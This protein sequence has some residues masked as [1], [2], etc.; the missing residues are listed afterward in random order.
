MQRM[1]TRT[2]VQENV[3]PSNPFIQQ[4]QQ[5]ESE[6]FRTAQTELI[7][8]SGLDSNPLVNLDVFDGIRELQQPE[9]FTRWSR[10]R[11]LYLNSSTLNRAINTLTNKMLGLGNNIEGYDD[12][13][14]VESNLY[15]SEL[16]AQWA[17]AQ[18]EDDQPAILFYIDPE[19]RYAFAD[20]RNSFQYRA[21][22]LA[23]FTNS[24]INYTI[25]HNRENVALDV[26]LVADVWRPGTQQRGW[27]MY[28]SQEPLL[29]KSLF[30]EVR[31]ESYLSQ[32]KANY[33]RNN[34][35]GTLQVTLP[36]SQQQ[37]IGQDKT[38]A[39]YK[40]RNKLLNLKRT[41]IDPLTNAIL[42]R[43]M[44]Q[45]GQT[46]SVTT[47]TPAALPNSVN[48][49]LDISK[50]QIYETFGLTFPTRPDDTLSASGERLKVL[51]AFEKEY[52]EQMREKYIYPLDIAFFGDRLGV[53]LN[54]Q[55]YERINNE[56]IID[57]IDSI[58]SQ[59]EQPIVQMQLSP[60]APTPE[61]N[62]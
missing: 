40:L 44:D 54:P 50:A 60:V 4:S 22:R 13:L 45:T 32:W 52:V 39:F 58:F 20:I 26:P 30:K 55:Q 10:Y 53:I 47:S 48:D 2:S 25:T 3:N 18:L 33:A 28:V 7:E 27:V 51:Y 23:G 21:N 31:E 6:L 56:N 43:F 61:T 14:F 15:Y 29:W 8:E 16:I 35:K 38:G 1:L 57:E 46:V 24:V 36:Y 37:Q 5:L 41:F 9:K 49:N 42:V 34:R 62:E 59:P 11:L 12:F 19:G 17:K